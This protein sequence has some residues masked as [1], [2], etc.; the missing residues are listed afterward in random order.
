MQQSDEHRENGMKEKTAASHDDTRNFTLFV[1]PN[2][3]RDGLIV[4]DTCDVERQQQHKAL[5]SFKANAT[6]PDN[7]T[8]Q[9]REARQ[10]QPSGS[11]FLLFRLLIC[12][13]SL[14]L[15]QTPAPRLAL[16]HFPLFR[17]RL[18]LHPLHRF[19]LKGQ[20]RQQQVV[21]FVGSIRHPE[22][23]HKGV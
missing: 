8:I 3:V 14:S 23:G 17:L 5:L 22:H 6:N 19:A 15:L 20:C 10:Q 2:V 18:S 13:W 16:T 11:H 7:P 21:R 12:C 9:M 4:L 1:P